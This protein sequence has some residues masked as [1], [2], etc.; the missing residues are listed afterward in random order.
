MIVKCNN[1]GNIKKRHVNFNL[2][3]GK[4]RK[5]NGA[6]NLGSF[7]KKLLGKTLSE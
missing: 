2:T 5:I 3:Q 7:Y 6:K 4:L 1:E